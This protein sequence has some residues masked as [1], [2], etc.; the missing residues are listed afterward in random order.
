MRSQLLRRSADLKKNVSGSQKYL[1]VL[2]EMSAVVS[3]HPL[4]QKCTGTC[5]P[6]SQPGASAN[7]Y[8]FFGSFWRGLSFATQNTVMLLWVLGATAGDFAFKRFLMTPCFLPGSSCASSRKA[9]F[10]VNGSSNT[11]NCKQLAR[12]FVA[13]LQLS[14]DFLKTLEGAAPAVVDYRT[15]FARLEGSIH[16]SLSG[17]V[18]YRSG[19]REQ[20]VPV[21]REPG[22]KHQEAVQPQREQCQVRQ[23]TPGKPVERLEGL[24]PRT[25]FDYGLYDIKGAHGLQSLGF[26][27]SNC[28]VE[29]MALNSVS[30]R[31]R[32]TNFYDARSLLSILLCCCKDTETTGPTRGEPVEN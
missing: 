2:R 21:E 14:E 3:S 9:R 31:P 28:V 24:H 13:N 29:L 26:K 27:V 30:W 5:C 12:F 16:S 19:K 11:A 22:V 23:V 4:F 18:L 20:D 17:V 15:T 1:D 7:C 8:N 10:T 6:D 25:V 32:T